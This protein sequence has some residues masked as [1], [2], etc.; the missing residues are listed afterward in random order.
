MDKE[1]AQ[2]KL[3]KLVQDMFWEVRHQE[4]P[5]TSQQKLAD[6]IGLDVR[7]VQAIEYGDSSPFAVNFILCM[8][9]ADDEKWQRVRETAQRMVLTK[10]V[11]VAPVP[12]L[13]T[14][15]A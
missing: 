13:E 11:A 7:S 1:V 12:Q 4:D 10:E 9:L 3:A 15:P 8:G 2:R 14:A 5:P 6:M